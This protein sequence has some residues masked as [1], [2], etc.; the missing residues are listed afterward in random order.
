MEMKVRAVGETDSK[1]VQE[2]EKELLEKHEEKFS[3]VDSPETNTIE[4]KKV[5]IETKTE[6]PVV[7]NPLEETKQQ[8]KEIITPS[9]ELSEEEV[10]KFIGNRYGKEIKSLD[11]FNQAREET[12][13]LPEDV[14]QYLKY[15]K[16]TG[17]GI[18]DFY[19]LQKNYDEMKP[20]NLLRDYLTAT[21]KGLDPEDISDLMEDFS[22]DEDVDDEK[23]IKKIKLAKKKTIAKAKDFFAEQQEKYKIPLESSREVTP[24]STEEDLAYKQYIAE[25]KT[26][27]EIT[28][29]RKEAY[30]KKTDEVF[31]EFKGFEFTIDDNKV[32]F[33]PGDAA[34][35]KK[36]HSD[37]SGFIGKHT[38]EDGTIKDAAGYHRSLAMAMHPEKFAKFFYE[39][40]K[41][42]SAD[43]TMRKMKNVNMTTQKVPEVS[44]TKSGM[45]IK[46]LSNDHGRGLKIRS[47]N[48]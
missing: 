14:S 24:K 44:N 18:N 6:T 4:T 41:S 2:V 17:R 33:S 46:S 22:F 9:S 34:E 31:S 39:Q 1:S 16:E 12:E 47:R 37:P 48:K 27:E 15:K 26:N 10:L 25:A 32:Y 19:Q 36:I 40:G 30:L 21:E 42:A 28:S 13:P 11:D 5:E 29:R 43:E 7:E 3:A 35:L 23:Q 45:Q 38:N 8:E 20:D